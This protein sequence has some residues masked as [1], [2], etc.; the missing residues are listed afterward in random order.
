MSN[1]WGIERA[2]PSASRRPDSPERPRMPTL[3]ML[4]TLLFSYLVFTLHSLI[5]DVI[6]PLN[7]T[8]RQAG[9]CWNPFYNGS[10]TSDPLPGSV[11]RRLIFRQILVK[12]ML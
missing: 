12:N 2:H 8:S 11:A 7:G 6:C 4:Q 5:T 1:R 9:D 10:L 3:L